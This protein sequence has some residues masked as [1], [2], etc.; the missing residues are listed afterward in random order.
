MTPSSRRNSAVLCLLLGSFLAITPFGLSAKGNS[1]GEPENAKNPQAVAEVQSGQRTTA[2]AAWW[3]FNAEDA[4]EALQAAIR[5]GAKRVIV[6]NVGKDWVVR[7]LQLASDQELFL[8]KGVVVTAM[9]GAYRGGGDSVFTANDLTNVTVRG[10]GAT[11]R[12]QK[13]DYIVGKVLKDLGWNR[14]YGQY[15]KAEWRMALAIH[16]CAKVKIEGLTLRDSGGDG[17]YIQGGGKLS[18]SKDIHIKEVICDNNYRQGISII[19]VDGLIVEDSAFNNTWGTPPSSG[20]DIEPD[21]A[22]DRI[23]NVIF[24]SCRFADNYGDGIEVFLGNLKT[25]SENVSILFDRCTVTSRRGPGIRLTRINDDGPDGLIEF[26]NCVVEGTEGY[27]LKVRDKSADRARVRFVECT[28]RDAARDRNFA[29]LWAPIALEASQ[30]DRQKRFGGVEFVRCV[31]EDSRPRPA[32][33]GRAETGLF[34]VTGDITVRSSHAIKSDLGAKQEGMALRVSEARLSPFQNVKVFSEPGRFGGWPANHGI[35][36]WENEILVGFSRGYYKDLGD[37]HNIDRERPEEHL[38]ARS[39]DG[40]ETWSIE[41]PSL[42]AALIPAGK[43]LHGIAPSNAKENPWRDCPGGIDFTHPDFAMALRMTG[44]AS[45]P[46]RFYYSTDRGHRWEGPFGLPM[47]GQ[48]GVAAR[49]D[50]LVNGPGECLLVLT[51]AK[52]NG[53]E[54]R[55][56]CA[57]TSDGGK[58]WE[59]VSW[60][61][62]DPK[63]YAIMPSTIRLSD[64]EL[65]TAIR[66][67][68]DEKARIETYR[69]LDNGQHWKLE[70]IPAPDL[71]TG[72]PP[73]MIRLKDGRVCLTYGHRAPPYGIRARVSSDG[74]RNWGQEI[75][76]RDDGGGTDLGYPRTVQRPDGKI[77]TIY[78]FHDQPKGD[79]YIAATIWSP[80]EKTANRE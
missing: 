80:D 64:S 13:E 10:Y 65:L 40:G 60:I 75:I 1:T 57:R 3:G 4:T 22:N 5:S 50:Y 69:S 55:P 34:N 37:S 11:V 73:S 53:E 27:G 36:S 23:K 6:P 32:I 66:C 54:G 62:R 68:D 71:G 44:V 79:R 21:S 16:G 58:T 25:N 51:A 43:A 39:L 18:Y 9:R 72:N 7:P 74:G 30:S 12:M 19:S 26:R 14:W 67:R 77:V 47:F 31:V 41:D 33:L 17:I 24:R 59:F 76:L 15:E 78:Y 29:D 63:G 38:L 49:T 8:E 42:H 20:V 52:P 45:G 56:F 70:N 28:I 61:N 35:W 2:N 46:S 48:S